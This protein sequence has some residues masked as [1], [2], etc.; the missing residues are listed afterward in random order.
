MAI[1]R[2]FVDKTSRRTEATALNKIRIGSVVGIMTNK[3][4]LSLQASWETL[5]STDGFFGGIQKAM[6]AAGYSV[7]NAGIWTRKFYKGGSYLSFSPSF[8]IIDW[9]GEGNVITSARL[10]LSKTAPKWAG[11]RKQNQFDKYTTNESNSKLS[12]EQRINRGKDFLDAARDVLTSGKNTLKNFSLSKAPSPV[13]V[14]V[15]NYFKQA[16]MIIE[17]VSVEFS[18]EMGPKGP[19]MGDFS[20]TLSSIEATTANDIGLINVTKPRVI[21]VQSRGEEVQTDPDGSATQES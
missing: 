18:E 20:V 14:E 1:K 4:A 8:R 12:A 16:N 13:Y 17:S 21:V 3:L 10:L 5:I 15:S 19:L 11:Q 2:I 9:H 6:G 7:F